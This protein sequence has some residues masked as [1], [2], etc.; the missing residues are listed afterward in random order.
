M[1][2]TETLLTVGEIA[3]RLAEPLHRIEYIIRS[4]GVAPRGWA[5]HARVFAPSDLQRIATEFR[6]RG[7]DQLTPDRRQTG[8]PASAPQFASVFPRRAAA[9]GLSSWMPS[10]RAMPLGQV[11]LD[12]RKVSR[13]NWA[14]LS[15]AFDCPWL[16]RQAFHRVVPWD[17]HYDRR[18]YCRDRTCSEY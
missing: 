9:V 4:R 2:E 15:A 14:V 6:L 11:L 16:H 17:A 7:Q 1:A 13:P 3:R 18:R 5:G 10:P 12:E 8:R